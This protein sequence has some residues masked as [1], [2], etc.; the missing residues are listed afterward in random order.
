MERVITLER[1]FNI[2]E[3]FGRKDDSLPSRFTDEPM[4]NSGPYTG[5]TVRNLDGLIDEYYRLMGYTPK[6]IPSLEKLKDL[7]LE[8]VI[9]SIYK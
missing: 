7:G 6:G 8:E 5:Q 9:E 1:A 4:P 2:R 3:G